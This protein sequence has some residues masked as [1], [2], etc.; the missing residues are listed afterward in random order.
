MDERPDFHL[1]EE[2]SESVTS[3]R[4]GNDRKA[5]ARERKRLERERKR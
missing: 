1:A 4:D 2:P 3:D 5:A